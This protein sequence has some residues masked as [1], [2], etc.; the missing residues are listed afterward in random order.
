[1]TIECS[2]KKASKQRK[3]AADQIIFSSLFQC[4]RQCTVAHYYLSHQHTSLNTHTNHTT[5]HTAHTAK[6]CSSQKYAVLAVSARQSWMLGAPIKASGSPTFSCQS[7]ECACTASGGQGSSRCA[8]VVA[9]GGSGDTYRWHVLSAAAIA[10]VHVHCAWLNACRL[11]GGRR[12]GRC[13]D[14]GCWPR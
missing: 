3:T 12:T 8:V 10:A 4:K 11:N 7:P 14:A 13:F 1:M 2:T 6:L 9:R 5:P